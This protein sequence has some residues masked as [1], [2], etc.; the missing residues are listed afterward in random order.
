MS[1]KYKLC[2]A[3]TPKADFRE[4]LR[5]QIPSLLKLFGRYDTELQQNA[6]NVTVKTC[7]I[8]V[9][10]T[11]PS[12]TLIGLTGTDVSPPGQPRRVK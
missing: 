5:D 7:F 3:N 4:A 8:L 1:S 9:D 2:A 10:A 12:L 11:T 6:A